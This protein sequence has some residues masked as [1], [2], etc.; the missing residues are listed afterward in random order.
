MLW[1]LFG[2]CSK[3][4]QAYF[5]SYLYRLDQACMSPAYFRLLVHIQCSRQHF[6]SVVLYTQVG[7]RADL[8]HSKTLSLHFNFLMAF[9][10][11]RWLP[12]MHHNILGI[13]LTT[14]L[15]VEK[16]DHVKELIGFPSTWVPGKVVCCSRWT[17]TVSDSLNFLQ[18]ILFPLWHT[19]L[20]SEFHF[21]KCINNY[22][23]WIQ[24]ISNVSF[25][26]VF[27]NIINSIIHEKLNKVVKFY[28]SYMFDS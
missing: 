26:G 11:G 21:L 3:I 13:E 14:G 17:L 4:N 22:I 6:C 7:R 15:D 19:I 23:A 9:P 25:I 24:Y 5:Q 1:I 12:T 27:G 8:L 20:V 28:T 2:H 10:D 18:A 16:H